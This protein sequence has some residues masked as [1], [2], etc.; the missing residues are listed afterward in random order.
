MLAELCEI[1]TKHSMSIGQNRMSICKFCLSGV[2]IILMLKALTKY[3]LKN[4]IPS[5]HIRF[6][7]LKLFGIGK[8]L[9]CS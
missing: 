3:F 8:F 5:A 2:S 9:V 4:S 1:Y 7:K 6:L